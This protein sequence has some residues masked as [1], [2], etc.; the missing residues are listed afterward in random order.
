[1]SM[2]CRGAW[3]GMVGVILL[4]LLVVRCASTPT[5]RSTGE[6]LDDTAMTTKVKATFVGDPVVSALAISVSTFRGVVSLSGIVDTDAERRR[7]IRLAEELA[8]VKAVDARN[9]FVRR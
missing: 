6:V 5:E 9:L 1:M 8:G 4:A 2:T 7:A 3:R